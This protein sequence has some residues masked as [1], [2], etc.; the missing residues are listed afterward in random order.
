MPGSITVGSTG[1]PITLQTLGV[2]LAGGILGARKGFLS[3]LVFLVLMSAGLP[4]L[5]GGRG[6]LGVWA[7][8]SAGYL[9]GWLVGVVVIGLLTARILPKY[10]LWQGILVNLLGGALVIY[11]FG[12]AAAVLPDRVRPG[13]HRRAAVPARRRAQGR[14]RRAGDQ[15]GAPVLPRSDRQHRAG[16]PA[17]AAGHEGVHLTDRSAAPA[18]T[19]AAAAAGRRAGRSSIGGRTWTYQQFADLVRDDRT[20]RAGDR[21]RHAG[22]AAGRRPDCPSS[23]ALATVFAAAAAGVPVIVG[24]PAGPDPALGSLPADTFLIAVT[25]G[26]SGRARPVLRTASS[27]TESFAPLA[28]LTGIGPDDRVLLTGPLHATLHLFAAVHTLALGAELT[29]RPDDATA[30]HAVPAVLAD[31]LD[32][33]PDTAPLR[34]AVV[35]G[36]A[37]PAEIAERARQRGHRG[38][39]VLRRRRTVLRRRPPVSRA[40]ATRSR[41]RR[42]SSGTA[43]S[44]S[45]PPISRSATPPGRPGR[46]AAA[47][48]AS[49]PSAIWPNRTV[50]DGGLLIRG[51]GD[52]AITT[53]GAT[54]I[55][56]DVEAVL[57]APAGR[58]RGRRCRGAARPAG[59]GRHRRH[60]AGAGCRPEQR[61]GRLLARC[62]GSS[63]CPAGG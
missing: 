10:P 32:A 58:G 28:E 3:V 45:A 43:C 63:R 31:L 56:E 59:S 6:G 35:A 37:L 24:D 40:A 61:C 47:T 27:W 50:P 9:V 41:A 62:C 48:T 44:G 36:T 22:R 25:S 53:G 11:V 2:M 39:R 49:P 7:G 16:R 15:A 46:S 42:C 5:S 54:V 29:D 13:D 17:G 33:L 55:A 60:R 4:L 34:T 51:R 8:T 21:R 57:A 38:D 20:A 14:G 18:P 1:V 23:A 52:A 30:V 19:A 12:I 26:T